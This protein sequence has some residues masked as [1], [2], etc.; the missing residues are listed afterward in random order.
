MAGTINMRDMRYLN[1]F[2]KITQ[3]P[4][5]SC[6]QYNGTIYFCVQKRN[7]YK[8][9]G[10]EAKNVKKIS[11]TLGKRIKII[12]KPDSIENVKEFIESIVTPA[13][14]KDLIVDDSEIIITAGNMQNKATLLGRNK[15]RLLEIQQVSRDFFNRELKVI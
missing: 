2:N 9:I 15:K 14:F 4:T 5:T 11:H 12:S 3:V 13:T 6:F 8:A 7:L 10:E 1:L